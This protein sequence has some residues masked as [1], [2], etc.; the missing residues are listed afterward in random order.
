MQ[1]PANSQYINVNLAPAKIIGWMNTMSKYRDGVY[2][3]A[4]SSTLE[5]NPYTALSNMNKHTNVALGAL[6]D[7]TCANDNWV[8]DITNCTYSS[9]ES[10]FNPTSD[11]LYGQYIPP[12]GTL[13]LSFNSRISTSAPSIWTTSD[14]VQRYLAVRSCKTNSVNAF[15]KII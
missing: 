11:P 14:V 7:T 3:D 15:N 1:Q 9:T 4:A 6:V 10:L 2:I 13:C 8:F 12:T 5:S